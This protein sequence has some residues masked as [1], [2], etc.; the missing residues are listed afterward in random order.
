MSHGCNLA[1]FS[2]SGTTIN[3]G[4]ACTNMMSVNIMR[5]MFK[6]DCDVVLSLHSMDVYWT[7]FH[8]AES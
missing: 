8:S 3:A 4:V 2:M 5:V 7:G 6:S 1:H